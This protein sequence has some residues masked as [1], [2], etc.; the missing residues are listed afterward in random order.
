MPLL[1]NRAAQSR[2]RYIVFRVPLFRM[3]SRATNRTRFIH[4]KQ[5]KN[6]EFFIEQMAHFEHQF[7]RVQSHQSR[8]SVAKTR[9]R[10]GLRTVAR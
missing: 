9:E 6:I 10:R 3:S 2:E 7:R 4:S 5:N 8:P 1:L